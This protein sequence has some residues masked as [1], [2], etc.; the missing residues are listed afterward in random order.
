M[1]LLFNQT[2]SPKLVQLGPSPKLNFCYATECT[3]LCRQDA[4]PVGQPTASKHYEKQK[5]HVKLISFWRYFE[6]C[7]KHKITKKTELDSDLS[8]EYDQTSTS[9]RLLTSV[10]G[11]AECIVQKCPSA[12]L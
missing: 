9:T 12:E 1:Q 2:I 3:D 10:R 4:L 11:S 7:T 8:S 6:Q 5:Q